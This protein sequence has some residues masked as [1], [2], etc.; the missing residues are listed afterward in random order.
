[1]TWHDMNLDPLHESRSI[2][3]I[4][5]ISSG[6]ERQLKYFFSCGALAFQKK[7]NPKFLAKGDEKE[8]SGQYPI[9]FTFHDWYSSCLI[10]AISECLSLKW[11]FL[12]KFWLIE[13]V[14][15]RAFLVQ[16]CYNAQWIML[17]GAEK[18]RGCKCN[19]VTTPKCWL[20][21]MAR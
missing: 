1:M 13:E 7:Y 20:L 12:G 9:R 15:R 21:M 2:T 3:W 19:K 6:S 5:M 10:E 4:W 17:V 8:M 18:P 11:C 14:S 16:K